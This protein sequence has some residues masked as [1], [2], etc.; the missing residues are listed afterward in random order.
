MERPKQQALAF[1]LGALLVGGVLGFSADRVLRDDEPSPVSKRSAFY[2]D[3]GLTDAQRPAMD[4]ILDSRNCR[5]D[6]IYRTV[7]PT[8]D[9]VYATVKPAADSIYNTIK[10]AVDSVKAATRAQINLLLTSEQRARFEQ[11]RK[12]NEARHKDEHKRKNQTP[13]K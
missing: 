8:A 2:D 13:C 6:S 9:S 5:V 7:R 3:I 12:D 1:L 4:S 10:P 11:I